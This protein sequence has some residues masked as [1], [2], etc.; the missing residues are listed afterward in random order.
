MHDAWNA[1]ICEAAAN[2]GFTCADV[3][4]AFNGPQGVEPA[5]NL[6]AADYI[7]PSQQGHDRIESVLTSAGFAPLT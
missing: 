4:H 6:L 7:H 2:N 3:Y 5:G 1:M